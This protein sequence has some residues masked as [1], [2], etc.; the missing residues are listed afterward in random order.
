MSIEKISPRM[1][2]A[3][4]DGKQLRFFADIWLSVLND[5]VDYQADFQ[6]SVQQNN[7]DFNF[8]PGYA[9]LAIQQAAFNITQN[10]YNS[11][12]WSLLGYGLNQSF[13]LFSGRTLTSITLGIDNSGNGATS[14]A[15]ILMKNLHLLYNMTAGPAD[16]NE[17]PEKILTTSVSFGAGYV[18]DVVVSIGNLELPSGD[19]TLF[20]GGTD[21]ANPPHIRYY[22]SD[23]YADGLLGAVG[24]GWT[25]GDL[26]FKLELS[27]Y[28]TS[29]FFVTKTFDLGEVPQ[30]T[31]SFQM[32]YDYPV[33]TYLKVTLYGSTTGAFS[34]EEQTF[35]DV[36]DGF[37]VPPY[38]Y[39]CVRVD[40]AA[41][42]DL[43]QTPLIDM[44]E[45]LYPKDRTRLREKGTALR[46]IADDIQKDFQPFLKP[47]TFQMS[48]LKIIER[49]ASGGTISMELEDIVP[50]AIQRIVSDSPLKN[51]RAAMYLG[52][53]VDGFSKSDLCRFFIGIVDSTDIV[54]KYRKETYALPLT[55]KNPI[56]ELKRKIPLPDQ[57][58]LLN[59]ENIAIN[60]DGIHV[61]DSM[62]DLMRGKA[63]I[64]ARYINLTSFS[65]QK[66]IIGP[67]AIV[68]RSNAY[69]LPDTRI[70]NPDEVAKLLTSLTM[71][72]D[73]YIVE[74]ESSR[75]MFVLH[76]SNA[77]AE[78]IW[79]DEKMV[80]AGI[81][82]AVPIEAVDKISL[83]YTDLLFNMCYCGCGWDGSGNNWSTSFTKVYANI[84]T[85]S[86]DDWAPGKA[87]YVSIMEKNMIEVSKWLGPENGYNG[88]TL[89]QL[90][91]ARLV[92]RYAYPPARILGVVVPVSEFMRTLGSVVQVYSV[93]FCKFRRRGIALSESLKFMIISKKYDQ[94][95]NRMRFD[96]MELT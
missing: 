41:N 72:A 65:G 22:N 56:L 82:D 12:W 68:R 60:H 17:D 66:Q 7:V 96:L 69:G 27:G 67:V 86:A 62:L 13:R 63:R 55:I 36:D 50:D 89:S 57:T 33:G 8:N 37:I 32:T 73:G 83:G 18:G 35:L 45:F 30:D 29:G 49:V 64:P 40:M 47:L 78:A 51:Y 21:P 15:V 28:E 31:G 87:L 34:G 94:A 6:A 80:K 24:W 42:A 54:P 88:E 74:D 95:A 76:D 4:R 44:L 38:R 77:P 91:T 25:L 59:F 1:Q 14:V 58:S 20:V 9:R 70:K 23:K 85:T 81:V 92:A 90:I 11:S 48:D 46:Y 16:P 5:A 75:I 93:E 26:Y 39:W 43:D 3:L 61:V 71:I 79:A 19:Y 84:N 2:K 10:Q 52:A 53:D